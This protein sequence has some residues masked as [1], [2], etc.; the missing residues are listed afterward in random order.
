MILTKEEI[1]AMLEANERQW[2]AYRE[3]M[4]RREKELAPIREAE[5]KK[6]EAEQQAKEEEERRRW[7]AIRKYHAMVEDSIRYFMKEAPNLRFDPKV[8]TPSSVLYDGYCKWC[9]EQ[10]IFPEA[11]RAFCWN[12][13]KYAR[14]YQIAPTNFNWQGRH[15]RGF[16]G[17]VLEEAP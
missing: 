13:K 9:K 8:R 6:R 3:K 12:L 11:L 4:M 14:E 15:I 10:N 1:K 7:E 16:R 17:V 2:E 5:R